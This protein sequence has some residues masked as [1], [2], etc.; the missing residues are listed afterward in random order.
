MLPGLDS[1]PLRKDWLKLFRRS[2][3]STPFGESL[4]RAA[5]ASAAR[6]L[7]GGGNLLGVQVFTATG[8][9]TPTSGTNSVI[10]EVQAGGGG[11]AGATCAATQVAAGNGG[12]GGGYAKKRI[13]S[14][15]SGVTVTV[16]AA[17]TAGVSATWIG[18]AGGNSSFGALVTATG[19]GGG[20]PT[21]N[22]SNFVGNS[23]RGSGGAAASGDINI[24]GCD[25][26]HGIGLTVAGPTY[27]GQGGAGGNSILGMGG[28]QSST[29]AATTGANGR[30]YGAGGGGGMAANSG[31]AN[32][33]AGA[34]DAM[35]GRP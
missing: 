29:G 11:G 23:P 12:G 13:T 30:G 10:V 35:K 28:S 27:L 22:A 8:V 2:L 24:Q 6:T 14:A 1:L 31:N 25:G 7:L 4:L 26:Q 32:G 21:N 15:F 9:Y 5:T 16:G 33:G 20:N 34:A 18:G 3:A 17:G 19:G